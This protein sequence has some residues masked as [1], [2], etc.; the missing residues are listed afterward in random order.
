MSDP[1]ASRLAERR[2]SRPVRPQQTV[3][4]IFHNANALKVSWRGPSDD[5]GEI[6]IAWKDTIR[7]DAFKR[8]MF[9]VDLICLTIALRDDKALE[10]NEEMNGW[11]SL[12][13]KLPEYLPGCQTLEVWFPTVAFPAFKTNRSVIYSRAE[14]SCKAS[15]L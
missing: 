1:V 14:Q 9:A 11:Q 2:K 6:V 3:F 13:E 12:V 8:D 4:T 10:V 15:K 7:I 5:N